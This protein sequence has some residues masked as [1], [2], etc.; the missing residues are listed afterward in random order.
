M[1]YRE[2]RLARAARLEEWAEKRAIKAE[3]NFA[4]AHDLVKDLPL[5]QPIL[6]GHH[7]ERAS[8]R[9]R[10]RV[11]GAI[12]RGVENSQKSGEMKSKAN[13][14]RT[15][16]DRAIYD[17]DAYAIDKLREKIQ[18]AE[19]LRDEIKAYN[20]SARKGQADESLLSEKMRS[21]LHELQSMRGMMGKNGQLPPFLGSNLSGS[22][23]RNRKRLARL[24]R[25]S[26]ASR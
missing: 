16:A 13:N 1:T 18:N 11:V 20:A 6:V 9:H 8:L 19:R 17:D 10:D 2:R 25:D 14:I 7:S 15:A 3:G 5:G 21:N 24:E 26:S 23:S 4:A 22:I 12:D